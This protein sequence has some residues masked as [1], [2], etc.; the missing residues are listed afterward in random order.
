MTI[1]SKTTRSQKE[2]VQVR[3]PIVVVMG[4]IDHGKT[5]LLDWYRKTKVVEEESGGI[6]QHIGAYEVTHQGKRITFIDTPGHEAF[7][8]LRSRGA[9]AADIAVLVVA[10]DEGVKPQTKEAIDIILKNDLPF[11]VAINKI[12]KSEANS[13]RVRS[14][15]AET[16]VLVEGYGGKVPAAEVSAKG[17]KNMDALLEILLLLADLEALKADPLKPAEGTV[18]ETNIDP[19]RG[20]SATLLILD[21]TLKK[22]D[23][24]AIGKSVETIRIL[25]D[26]LGRGIDEAGPSSP[27]LVAGLSGA[28]GAGDTFKTFHSKEAAEDF[29]ASLPED[30]AK[31]KA[32][33]PTS[34][35]NKP[36]FNII[37]KSDVA[38]SKEALEDSLKKL[39][40]EI[41]RVRI[42]RSEAGDINES[43]VKLAQATNLVTIVGFNVK[44]NPAVREL[45]ENSNIRIIR[46][47]IIYEIMNEVK[48]AM[49]DMLPPET[50]RTDLGRAKILKMFKKDGNKQIVGGRVEEG[51]I[52]KGAKADIK[53]GKDV[54]AGSGLILELQRNKVNAGEVEKGAEFGVMIDS[55]TA[56]QEG[57]VLEIFEEEVVKRTL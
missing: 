29:I 41:I 11:A 45:A 21:G 14:Q 2:H 56:I 27:I 39:D 20:I 52:K 36:V 22:G 38:G 37:L 17:G 50:K 40:S 12:D 44:V 53:R 26:F 10:A 25:E 47:E 46:G 34:D 49:E 5:K 1:K 31:E 57:D 7:S 16:G 4:H 18:V 33:S 55:K 8:R 48:R 6:T 43:D 51:I 54:A 23:I 3:P 19:K 28:P 32:G 35:V 42:L 24:V 15:L 30:T 9:K 13:E